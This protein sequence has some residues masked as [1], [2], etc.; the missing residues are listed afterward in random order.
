MEEAT[1]FSET[2]AT[3]YQNTWR[4]MPEDRYFSPS[5]EPRTLKMEPLGTSESLVHFYQ[6]IRRHNQGASNPE[7]GSH[8]FQSHT[9]REK[10]NP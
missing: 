8:N 4:H 9:V 6:S 3:F 5:Y 10:P 1:G 7:W 2:S